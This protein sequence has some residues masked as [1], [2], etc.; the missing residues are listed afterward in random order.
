MS[1]GC[2]LVKR[3]TPRPSSGFGGI[4]RTHW[5]ASLWVSLTGVLS[6]RRRSLVPWYWTEYSENL[7]RVA[8]TFPIQYHPWWRSDEQHRHYTG[9]SAAFCKRSK[10]SWSHRKDIHSWKYVQKCYGR[11]A[12]SRVG[13]ITRCSRKNNVD[14]YQTIHSLV[15]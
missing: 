2:V 8:R 11:V 6:Q 10:L 13:I 7:H 12:G 15:V 4:G 14:K 3:V 5:R 9:L 1:L